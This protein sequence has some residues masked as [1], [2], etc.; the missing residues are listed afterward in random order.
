[1]IVD[2]PAGRWQAFSSHI[3]YSMLKRRVV[4]EQCFKQMKQIGFNSVCIQFRFSFILF[5]ILYLFRRPWLFAEHESSKCAHNIPFVYHKICIFRIH[6]C[7]VKFRDNSS[8]VPRII[9]RVRMDGWVNEFNRRPADL[10]MSLKINISKPCSFPTWGLMWWTILQLSERE[11]KATVWLHIYD[12]IGSKSF[13]HNTAV[14]LFDEIWEKVNLSIKRYT[15]K[16]SS[17]SGTGSTQ[18]RE[19]NWGATWMK[20]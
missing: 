19:D 13:Y 6:F 15:M 11:R 10:K 3:V 8:W 20:K 2:V 14:T 17:G 16:R 4:S 18:P 7:N 5:F 1:M 12:A 9:S